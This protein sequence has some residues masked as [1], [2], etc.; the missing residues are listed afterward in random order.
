MLSRGCR[1]DLHPRAF[2]PGRAASTMI[3]HVGC[4]VHQVDDAPSYDLVVFSTFA[5]TF[6]EW[7][8][9]AAAEDGLVVE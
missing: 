2:G 5:Q 8:L 4:L 9:H 3:A 6:L 7:L 1:V